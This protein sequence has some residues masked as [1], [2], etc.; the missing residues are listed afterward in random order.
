[1]FPAS[2][3]L[4]SFDGVLKSFQNG[5]D[6]RRSPPEGPPSDLPSL[7]NEELETLKKTHYGEDLSSTG[8]SYHSIAVAEDNPAPVEVPVPSVDD[9]TRINVCGIDG[10]NQ[11]VERSTFYFILA[12]AAIVEFRYST[13]DEKPYFYNKLFDKNG[14]LWVDGNV[15]RSDVK[16]HTELIPSDKDVSVDILDR[17]RNDSQMPFL[18]RHDP[19]KTDKSPSSHALGWAVKMQQALE[20]NCIREVPTDIET[21]CIKD[22]PLFSTSV[23]RN[24]TLTGLSPT[25]QW[26]SHVLVACSKRIKDSRLLLE[27][28][29][30]NVPLRNY[31]FP[32]Q[33]IND[34]TLKLVSTDS[35]LLPRLLRPGFRTP[36][37]EAIPVARK[38]IVDDAQGGDSRFTPLSCY[39]LSKHQ[40][41]TYI[42]LEVPKFMWEAD[43]ERVLKAVSIVAWQHELGHRA[44]LVQLAADLR[45]QLAYEKGILEKQTVSYLHRNDLDF[46]E[47]Y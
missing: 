41:H 18:V 4:T 7:T 20:L 45:C 17:I 16:L 6:Y 44:P 19:E 22:G 40:P 3:I 5:E 39:Y 15:F 31:W 37:M 9:L 35:I 25:L 28:L 29:Q 8:Y 14:V 11:R 30:K 26:K 32:D 1:M 33:N 24:D 27:A 23:S 2:H 46:P 12:R 21:V 38:A 10:S 34:N 13:T 36:F 43:K 47:D 42:R